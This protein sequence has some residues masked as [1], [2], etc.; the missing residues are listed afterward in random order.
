MANLN[1]KT[2]AELM[3]IIAQKENEIIDLKEDLRQLEK[4]EKYDDL[5]DEIRGVFDKLGA[6]GF[7]GD[8][9]LDLVKTMLMSGNI[10]ADRYP[11]RSH[12][13]YYR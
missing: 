12:A 7:T 3:E 2:K 10:P 13:R 9:A 6:K 1:G 4:C 8:A 11:G 5:T